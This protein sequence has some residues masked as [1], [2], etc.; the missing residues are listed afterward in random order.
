MVYQPAHTVD[1]AVNERAWVDIREGDDTRPA[2]G[3]RRCM[4]ELKFD[5][6]PPR[7]MVELVRHFNLQREAYSKYTTAAL[8]LR[9]RI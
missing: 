1:F 5:G 2:F 3:Y 4:L 6:T 9:G 7:W 8:Q